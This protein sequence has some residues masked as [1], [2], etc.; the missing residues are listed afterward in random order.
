MIAALKA[1]A[2]SVGLGLLSSGLA[3]LNTNQG[4]V[5]VAYILIGGLAFLLTHCRRDHRRAQTTVTELSVRVAQLE[6]SLRYEAA[7]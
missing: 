4:G 6:T 3:F 2:V 1:D 7:D 5:F